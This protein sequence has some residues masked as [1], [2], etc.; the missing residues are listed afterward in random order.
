MIKGTVY[1]AATE[2][3]LPGANVYFSDK[4]GNPLPDGNGMAANANGQYSLQN[5]KS[6]HYITASFTGYSRKTKTTDIGDWIDFYLEPS[7]TNLPELEVI[8]NKKQVPEKQPEN[9]ILV[10]AIGG[11]IALAVSIFILTRRKK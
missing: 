2:E 1:D 10:Y 7:V 6:N 8:G 5:P 3:T 11:A 4:N 9:S